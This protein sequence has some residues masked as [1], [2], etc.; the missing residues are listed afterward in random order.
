MSNIEVLFDLNNG[1]IGA[2]ATINFLGEE[3]KKDINAGTVAKLKSSNNETTRR[4]KTTII[5][6]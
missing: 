2:T 6:N 1:K 5:Y 4:I 3:T